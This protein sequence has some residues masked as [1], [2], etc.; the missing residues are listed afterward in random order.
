MN[1]FATRKLPEEV[2]EKLEQYVRYKEWHSAEQ[3]MTKEQLLEAVKD[4][5]GI[6]SVLSDPLDAEVLAAAPNLKVI[7]QLAVGFNNI[8]VEEA[9]KRGIRVTNT[10]DVLTN[11]TAD[12]TFALLLAAARK[13]S[14]A[15]QEVRE[16]NW[17]SWSL[18]QLAGKEL[19]GATIGILGFGRIGQAVARRAKGF[20]MDVIYWNRSKKPEAEQT[21]GATY[22]ELEDVLKQ[23]DFLVIMLPFAPELKYLIGKEELALMKSDAILVNTARGGLVDEQALY[24]A[25][26]NGR[27]GAAGLDVFEQEPVPT[28]HPLLTLPNVEVAPHIGSSTIATRMEMADLTVRNLLA[29]L[30]NKEPET[31]VN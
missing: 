2:V 10:P 8:D 14:A 5:E 11:A 9:T 7:S 16:G 26:K 6:I 20:D 25:L 28:D 4:A 27:L 29:V 1:V 31:P 3:P 30:Q 17:Q 24:E 23:A 12:L 15:S 18:L 13:L 21:I 19:S 22:H